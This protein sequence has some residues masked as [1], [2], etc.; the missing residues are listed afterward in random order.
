VV[1]CMSADIPRVIVEPKGNERENPKYSRGVPRTP[2]EYLG[3]WP[4]LRIPPEA[5]GA[6]GLQTQRN[7]I[8][9][10]RPPDTPRLFFGAL[11][12]ANNIPV[13]MRRWLNG[14]TSRFFCGAPVLAATY[15][16]QIIFFRAPNLA[17]KHP[18]TRADGVRT[19][20]NKIISGRPPDTPRLFFGALLLAN[21]VPVKMR[22]WLNGATSRFFCGAPVLAATYIH[23][24]IFFRAPNLAGKHPFTRADGVRTQKNKIISRRPPDIPRLFSG[25]LFLA[26]N[27]PVEM[28]R[29][30]NGAT[31]R[32]F[33]GAPILAG[34][35]PFTKRVC[36]SAATQIIFSRAPN[37]AG[38]H[39]LKIHMWMHVAFFD[40]H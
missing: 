5:L 30:L 12:L 11:L 21:N 37:L 36:V 22:R 40:I 1:G 27:I 14:A 7:K 33:C 25:T 39:P 19:Q 17:G 8:I 32:F 3:F 13:K 38:K 31:S 28:R 6:K 29:W 2:G 23:Q 16:H 34:T 35:L 10:G 26:N 24:I 18:F 4:S 20:K 9:S 15:I